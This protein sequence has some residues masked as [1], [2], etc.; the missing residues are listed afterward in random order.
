MDDKQPHDLRALAAEVTT[1]LKAIQT[2]RDLSDNALI[3]A[4]PDLRSQK[5]WR[6]RLLAGR[7]DGLNPV[8]L[9]TRLIR[10]RAILDGGLPDEVF[11][12]DAPFA[13]EF[14]ARL[15]K[16]EVATNDRRILAALAA[17]GCGKTSTTRWVLAQGAAARRLVRCRPSWRNK[18]L[19]ICRGVAEVLGEKLESGSP[20]DA[21]AKCIELLRAHET[22]LFFDQAHEAG[23]ALMHLLRVFVDETPSRFV[24]LAY[25]TAFKQVL[26]G[27]SDAMLEAHAFLGRCQKPVF[28]L[29]RDGILATDVAFHLQRG[30]DLKADVAKSLAAKLTDPL[31]RAT[32]LRLLEDAIDSA[33]AASEQDEAAPGK[34]EDEVYRLGKMRPEPARPALP[35]E[36]DAR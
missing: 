17:N 13:V 31:R 10:I 30:A 29:Y 7:L 15:A 35:E 16:L 11:H 32:N 14:R 20:A 22:T 2:E 25:N 23:V 36:G 3:A 1:R 9:R 33:R 5:T 8:R 27:S 19:H 12:P 24:Y 28:D 34:I 4:Y 6:Q 18:P 26:T 21:E